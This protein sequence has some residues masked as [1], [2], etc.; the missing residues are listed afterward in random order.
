MKA[1]CYAE[2]FVCSSSIFVMPDKIKSVV[3]NRKTGRFAVIDKDY[4]VLLDVI[5][6]PSDLGTLLDEF[7]RESLREENII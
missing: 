5:D 1:E 3:F 6:K 7:D 4:N 2:D